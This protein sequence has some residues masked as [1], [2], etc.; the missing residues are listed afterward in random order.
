MRNG[1]FKC[2]NL[3][4]PLRG[5]DER[6]SETNTTNTRKARFQA[7]SAFLREGIWQLEIEKYS[8]GRRAGLHLLRFILVVS[9]GFTEHRLGLHAAGLTFIS[10]LSVV[11]ILMLML[12]LTK[13]CGMYGWAREKLRVQ[14]DEMIETFFE[15]KGVEKTKVEE[16]AL[17]VATK[18]QPQDP[19]AGKAFGRQARDLRDQILGQID[20]KINEF[21]FG[22]MALVG[23]LILAWTVTTTFGQVEA[24]M[25]EIW[26]VARPRPVWKRLLLYAGTLMVL[27]FLLALTMS[28]PIL[29][30]VK[31][32]LDATLGATSYTK[33]AGDALVGLLNSS[34]FSYGV[35]LTFATLALA[36]VFGMMPNRKVQVRAAL[37]GGFVT[38]V[39]L[40]VW[41]RLCIILQFGIANSSAAYGS[42][43]LLPILIVW[44]SFNWRIILIGS[45]MSY[46]FQCVHSRVRDLPRV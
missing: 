5:G 41:M 15:Q 22:L 44:I 10:L 20:Q 12:L 16:M 34:L 21:N 33:W 3:G 36:F 29:R 26:L 46:A 23:F 11:P 32:V 2:Y 42:F 1:P 39:L 40:A 30:V 17:S 38:A 18:S 25:N 6:M 8:R 9:R 7:L 13:P 31:D 43:A 35:T 27:P 24:S 19:E 28:L 14:T 4:M 37:E 45:N